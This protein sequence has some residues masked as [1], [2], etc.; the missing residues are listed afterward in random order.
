VKSRAAVAW[1][2][3]RATVDRGSGRRPRQ[4]PGEVPG[5]DR[6]D[7]GSA[8]TDAF[9]L[10]GRDPEGSVSPRFLGHEGGRHR[11]GGGEP[12]SRS[13]RGRPTH[14]IPL[15]TPRMRRV[16]V[17]CRSGRTNLC[18]KIRATQ[19]KG[20]MPDGHDPLFSAKGQARASLHGHEHILGVHGAARNR[21]REGEC[22]GP[23]L[24]KVCL[25]RGAAITTGI[26]RGG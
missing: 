3:G 5:Q 1:A 11:P 22:N 19:G 18:Q 4:K 21:G 6:R 8:T 2:A 13:V 20:L 12:V 16:Q 9:T 7:R 24:D 15:Y 25:A 14:V 23:P 17:S 26:G 10:S